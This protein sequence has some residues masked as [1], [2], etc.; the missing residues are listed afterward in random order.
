MNRAVTTTDLTPPG[1]NGV[2][3]AGL[4]WT[5]LGIVF[6]VTFAP[7]GWLGVLGVLMVTQ[8]FCGVLTHRRFRATRDAVLPD[9]L[10]TF[11]FLELINKTVTAI[12]VVMNHVDGGVQLLGQ[13]SYYAVTYVA[14]RYQFQAA[15]VLLSAI[16]IFTFIWVRLERHRIMALWTDP[17]PRKVWI[18]YF[19]CTAG[20]FAIT[21][22]GHTATMG[23][24]APL[25]RLIAIGG[26]AVLLGGRGIYALERRR[27]ALPI[28]ALVPW[29]FLAM[30]SGMKSELI[31]V[32][33]PVLLPLFRR[34]NKKRVALLGV[35]VM[36]LVG[37]LFPYNQIWRNANWV[38]HE[39]ITAT[40]A[41]SRVVDAWRNKGVLATAQGGTA[42]WLARGS[43][44]D[45]GGLVMQICARDG[46]LG[47]FLL[48][49]LM[50]IFVPRFLWP[51]KPTYEP[52]AW[53]T[54]YIGKATSPETATSSTGML[55]PT[56]LYWMFG[57]LGVFL[58]MVIIAVLYFVV[59][60][61]LLARSTRSLIMMG[62]LFALLARSANLEDITTVYAVSGPI[63]LLVYVRLAKLGVGMLRGPYAA[64][65]Q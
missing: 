8:S 27:A 53:F 17:L 49:G 13:D 41:A 42:S 14:T 2:L 33:M 32:L 16:V 47:P 58:G 65:K 1:I 10:S 39:N 5:C 6:T 46:H 64:S 61:T 20:Y 21:Y 7:D 3:V 52:G 25:L 12:G 22:S 45:A 29:V 31:L 19:A 59:W 30:R 24:I 48:R 11:L 34:L 62:A 43:S 54:W 18:T 28:L 56:E 9:F 38:R 50:T 37:F 51:D 15:L 57:P 40:Q 60:R 44:V 36:F 26:L 23:Q 35:F 4:L 55:L 63:I